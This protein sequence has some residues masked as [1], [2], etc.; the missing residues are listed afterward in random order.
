[1]LEEA[2]QLHH[3]VPPNYYEESIKKNIFQRF[4]HLRRF[5]NISDLA[6]PVKGSIL[7][8]G[9]ADG[10][11]SEVIF[12]KT[13][14]KKLV[15][16]DVLKSSV[17]YASKRFRKNPRME[18]LVADAEDIPFKANQFE[19]VFCL[20]ALE[21]VLKPQKAILEMKRVLKPGGYLII[22]V[23][24][25]SLLFQFLWSLVL[26]TWGRHWRETHVNSFKE[27][28]SLVKVLE[29]CGFQVDT[30]KKFLWGMLQAVRAIKS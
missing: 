28:K 18:F 5:K 19:A 1:M 7:D 23:P 30:D 12:K 17:E 2:A 11:F 13:Q 29:E 25:D 22:L 3:N 20:E 16:V 8:I 21:H 6:L 9:S 15:G 14:A 26:L 24:T 27:Q 4:W 10:T